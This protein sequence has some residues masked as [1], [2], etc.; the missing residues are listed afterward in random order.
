MKQHNNNNKSLTK[1]FI[2]IGY[3][4]ANVIDII[5]KYIYNCD[6]LDASSGSSFE[7]LHLRQLLNTPNICLRTLVPSV[8]AIEQHA[9]HTCIQATYLWKLSH[10]KLDIPDP[11][12][13]G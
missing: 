4:P 3:Q 1:T 11:T 13:W 10:L 2:H 8:P 12:P 5:G 9:R 7:A 6:G